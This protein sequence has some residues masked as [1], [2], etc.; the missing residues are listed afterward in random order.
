MTISRSPR[1]AVFFAPVVVVA[2]L[3]LGGCNQKQIPPAPPGGVYRSTSAGASFDQS[4][5]IAGK[6]GEYI[7][8]YN[9]LSLSRASYDPNVI[10]LAAANRGVVYS[11][12]DG[13]TWNT[14]NT[15]LAN[16]M[17]AL[18]LGNRTVVISGTDA[19]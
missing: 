18:V 13:A 15:P 6:P 1:L 17:G 4:V 3:A 5:T 11:T 12:D 10:Y 8:T 7:A 16:N 14:L 19:A 2:A 9:L